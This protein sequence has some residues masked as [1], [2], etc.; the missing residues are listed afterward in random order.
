MIDERIRKWLISAN[1]DYLAASNLLFV[2]KDR[3]ITN[4]VCYLSQQS[5]EKFLKAF[6]IYKAEPFPRTHNLELLLEKCKK[7]DP[8]F[9]HIEIGRLTSY[10]TSMRYPDEFRIPAIS[11]AEDSYDISKIVRKEILER[12]KVTEQE[13]SLFNQ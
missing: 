13:I 2:S 4:V 5:T 9:Q 10:N 7:C 3:I 12:L 11:E 6:L 1:N 8:A